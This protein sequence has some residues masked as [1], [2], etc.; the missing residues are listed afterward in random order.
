[1]LHKE[2]KNLQNGSDIRGY[3]I[4]TEGGQPVNLTDEAV[5][6]IAASFG[7][8]LSKRKEIPVTGLRISVGTDSRISAP[9]LKAAAIRGLTF[10]GCTVFDCNMASTPAMF[11]S[12]VIKGRE[13]DGSI[14]ITASHLPFNRNGLK[15][16]IPEGGLEQQNITE[17]LMMAQEK[18]Y[19]PADS[20]GKVVTVDLIS[21]YAAGLV[22][23]IQEGV[24]HPEHFEKPLK[25]FKIL[26]DAG[27]GGGGFFA[28]KVLAPL[29]AD[30]TGSQFL[31]PDGYFPNHMPNPENEA[32]MESVTRAVIKNQAD[33]GIIFDTDVDRAGAVAG[34]GKE[35]NK[36]KL[37]ALMSSIVL[38]K[39][40][41]TT[42]V[43]DSVTSSGLTSFIEEKLNGIHHRFKRGYKNVINEAIRL[44]QQGRET[45]L[46]IETSGHGA[47]KENFFLDD[48][49]YLMT[50]LIIK[51]AT[52]KLQGN[53]TIESL[54]VEL[55]EPVESMEFR[56]DINVE[57]FQDYGRII[58]EALTAYAENQSDW[59]I[60]PN[61]YEGIRVSFSKEG[62]NGWFLLRLS[63][64]DSLIPLNIESD[65][66]GGAAIIAQKLYAFLK[67][68]PNL[69][70]T[71]L[72][73]YLEEKCR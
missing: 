16:F 28:Y 52:L 6:S 23:L 61:N 42:I 71:P 29:G 70:I 62:G 53:R 32:A 55:A 47:L 3:A 31:E 57:K 41:H 54:I 69:D 5:E 34:N 27:N 44:N 38:E 40:P 66:I 9:R 49:A 56:M 11:M 2:W 30:I 68:Y 7:A 50:K 65:S 73:V 37:I 18:E 63:L 1:M 72:R 8:W 67:G 25:G 22:W 51:M 13:Y 33:L 19:V 59:V 46:A 48:G 58:I 45:H 20:M 36:N 26:V 39:Y 21:I 12:T 14:M 35:I 24:N 17:V 60:A 43:T 15:F 4:E 64:H 10:V